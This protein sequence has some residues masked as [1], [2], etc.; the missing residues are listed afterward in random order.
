MNAMKYLWIV[1][2]VFFSLLCYHALTYKPTPYFE[3]S[4]SLLADGLGISMQT[5]GIGAGILSSLCLLGFVL[6][7][8][9]DRSESA[10]KKP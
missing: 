4:L 7:S 10:R 8:G 6:S 5:L 2:C 3:N 9:P 1:A